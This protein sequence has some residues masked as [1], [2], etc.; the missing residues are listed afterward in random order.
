MKI[1]NYK[2]VLTFVTLVSCLSAY[3]EV[4]S[5]DK[6]QEKPNEHEI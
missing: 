3:A 5:Q 4:K 2:L 1:G 6:A